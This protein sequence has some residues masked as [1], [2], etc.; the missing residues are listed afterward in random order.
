MYAVTHAWFKST[1]ARSI[2]AQIRVTKRPKKSRRKEK[3]AAPWRSHSGMELQLAAPPRVA[4]TK[5]GKRAHPWPT[6][7]LRVCPGAK[8]TNKE[9]KRGK[10]KKREKGRNARWK[11]GGAEYISWHMSRPGN[12]G[13]RKE[14]VQAPEVGYRYDRH[15]KRVVESC[16][17]KKYRISRE[18]RGAE[19]VANM[20]HA[21]KPWRGT[22]S[23]KSRD[24]VYA[25]PRTEGA[26]DWRNK[27]D[28]ERT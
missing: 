23:D 4:T 13:R 19:W 27:S 8:A 21:W 25:V 2:P 9:L 11:L 24:G 15:K 6:V 28:R 12:K 7:D 16:K 1:C 10:E 26:P 14:R 20:K 18:N 5:R 22:I 3:R 17:K